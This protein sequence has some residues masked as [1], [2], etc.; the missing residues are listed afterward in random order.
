MQADNEKDYLNL[1]YSKD[2]KPLTNY[3]S[4]LCRYIYDKCLKK[5]GRLLDCGCGRGEHL[6]GFKALG[7]DVVGIDRSRLAKNEITS[8]LPVH[9]LD[10]ENDDFP[11][12]D[13]S[14]DCVFCKSII[15]HLKNPQ[16][17]LFQI[18][19][20][21]KKNGKLVVMTPDWQSNYKWFYNDYTHVRPYTEPG[22]KDLLAAS[23]FSAVRIEK[24][25]QL[26]FTWRFSYLRVI[27]RIVRLLPDYFKKS[28]IV[29]FS[30][31]IMLLAHATK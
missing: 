29:F 9:F 22:L 17:M 19:R 10:L 18:R 20:V 6:A 16:H 3:P 15:E 14:F 13:E 2:K 26:P 11:F 28:K 8:F 24:M 5:N 27:P 1:M 25:F 23:G 4:R 31:E 7:L 12:P 30:K 21:L